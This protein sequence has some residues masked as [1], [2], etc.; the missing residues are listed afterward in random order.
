[1]VADEAR[2]VEAGTD[3]V[4]SQGLLEELSLLL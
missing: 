3:H 4:R 1:M 2:E